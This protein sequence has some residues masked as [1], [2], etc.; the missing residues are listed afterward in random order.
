MSMEHPNILYVGDVERGRALSQAVEA[1]GGYVYLPADTM[2]ALAMYIHYLPDIVVIEASQGFSMA[3][4]VH[5]HLGSIQAAPVLV[6]A[7]AAHPETWMLFN[8][9]ARV[10]PYTLSR[11]ALIA[12][13]HEVIPH[14]DT[15]LG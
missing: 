4:D 3:L 11:E 14:T 1:Q 8:P 5:Q 6:L 2:E 9:A 12:A 15:Q 13:I 10:L 7:D